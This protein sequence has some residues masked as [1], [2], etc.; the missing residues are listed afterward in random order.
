[1]LG[2]G[3]LG[4]MFVLSALQMGYRVV[5]L[6][7][8]P[9]SPAGLIATEHLQ[10]DYQDQAALDRLASC[11]AVSIEFE[12]IPLESLTWLASKT[13]VSPPPK[14]VEIAQDRVLEKNFANQHGVKTAVFAVIE[15]A[16]QVQAAADQ[17]GFPAILKTAR[18][19]YDGKGQVV[20]ADVDT[21]AKAFESL[22]G[23]VCVLEQKVDLQVEVSVVL[24]RGSDARTSILP[25]A[26]NSHENG[27]LDLSIVPARVDPAKQDAAIEMAIKLANALEYVGVL[28][29]EFFI[30]QDGKVLMNEMAPRP[31]NSGHYSLDA[32]DNSQFDLQVLAVCNLPMPDCKL[33]SPVVM[34]NLLG[35]RWAPGMPDWPSLLGETSGPDASTH[36]HLY[37]KA[38][39]RPGRKMGHVNF[40]AESLDAALE[41]ALKA[42]ASL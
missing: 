15:N 25:V 8:D 40:L 31:H 39:A 13:R 34:L 26:E 24:A 22:G 17:V 18:L 10:A 14:A 41:S 3:Q 7:P 5:V 36:L 29:V 30:T 33:L 4:R 35:E 12:N 2:G 9:Q 11:D 19:G 37:G 16:D 21:L 42:K 20:C 32:V 28:A 1:M 27:I 23:V 38:E 6:D